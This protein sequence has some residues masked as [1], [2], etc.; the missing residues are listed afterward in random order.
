MAGPLLR[1]RR[2]PQEWRSTRRKLEHGRTGRS[3]GGGAMAFEQTS[4]RIPTPCNF[5][6]IGVSQGQLHAVHISKPWNNN[7]NDRLSIWVL[8]DYAG[9][10]WTLKHEVSAMELFGSIPRSFG[11]SCYFKVHAIHPEHDLIF[12]TAGKLKS[13]M[14]YNMDEKKVR[15]I[16]TL[17]G[18]DVSACPLCSLLLRLAATWTLKL[19]KL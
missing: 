12:L 9:L 18:R 15:F 10:Q 2:P 17:G 7:N 11:D 16:W 5:H 14:S 4:G 3:S 1:P 13:L 6:F 8:E 19:Q